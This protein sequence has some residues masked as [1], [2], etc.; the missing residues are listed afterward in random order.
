MATLNFKR[1]SHV[2]D[3]KVVHLHSLIRFLEPHAAYFAAKGFI[4]PSEGSPDDFDYEALTSLFISTD[5]MPQDLVEA[6]Y[7]VNEMATP[8]GMQDI[9]ERCEEAGVEL[10][11]GEEPAPTDV[12][13]QTWLQ[14]PEIFERAHNEYQLDRPR[15]F[16][17]FFN[18]AGKHVSPLKMPTLAILRAMEADLTEWFD[19]KKCGKTVKVMPFERDDGLWFLVRRGEP[20]KRQGAVL[21][22]KSGSVVYRPEKHDVLVYTPA[23]A[24]LRIS[25]VTKKERE[26]YLRVFG[27]HLFE[28]DDFFSER[29]KYTLEPLRRDGKESL[30]CSDITG[31]DE[32][33]L[34]EIRIAWGGRHKEFETRRADDIFAAYEEKGRELPRHAPL[35]LA[36]FKV[37]FPDT[38]KTRALVIYPPNKINIKRHDDSAVLDAWMAKRGFILNQA[39]EEEIEDDVSMAGS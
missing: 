10:A 33:V 13:V 39:S 27:K 29:G 31:L 12:A 32:I 8:E 1:F 9:L 38:K 25:P 35:V 34:R 4:L 5:D 3:L 2:D 18:P 22:G 6:L 26:L 30:V 7:Q 20:I 23:L 11:L 37:N 36:K 14:A 28:G 19:R 24:E 15:S 17:S 16:E 21:D